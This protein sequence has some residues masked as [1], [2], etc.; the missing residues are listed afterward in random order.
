MQWTGEERIGRSGKKG[1]RRAGR[2]DEVITDMVTN[3]FDKRKA[4]RK[5]FLEKG[6]TNALVAL[7]LAEPVSASEASPLSLS[8]DPI[9]GI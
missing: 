9:K 8:P 2:W 7:Q 4:P 1:E 5:E 6:V 3:G